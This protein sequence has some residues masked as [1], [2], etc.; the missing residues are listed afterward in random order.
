MSNEPVS[1]AFPS[2]HDGHPSRGQMPHGLTKRELFAA[3][4]MQSLLT[5]V[6]GD[7]DPQLWSYDEIAKCAAKS[8]DAL[9]AALENRN[10]Q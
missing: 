6:A 3:M 8:A 2:E 5:P 10:G 1:Y 7:D 9:L 4:A